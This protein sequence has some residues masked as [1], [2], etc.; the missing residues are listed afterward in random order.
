MIR[1]RYERKERGLSLPEFSQMTGISVPTIGN[2]ER[3][4]KPSKPTAQK[5]VDALEWDKD[6]SLL[7][8][9]IRLADNE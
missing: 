3:G 2:V 4:M 7:F 8:E 1:L 9:A 6:P 5:I